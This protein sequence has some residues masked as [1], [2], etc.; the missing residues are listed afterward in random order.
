MKKN[1]L[2]AEVR[3]QGR[4]RVHWFQLFLVQVEPPDCESKGEKIFCLDTGI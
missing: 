4:E 1:D 3:S 2:G